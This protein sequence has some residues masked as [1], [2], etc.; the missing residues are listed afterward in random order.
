MFPLLRMLWAAQNISSAEEGA[1]F[2]SVKVNH[3]SYN[4]HSKIGTARRSW[5]IVSA[6]PTQKIMNTGQPLLPQLCPG[7]DLTL[8]KR[9]RSVNRRFT[10]RHGLA[11]TV[12][13]IEATIYCGDKI[14]FGV[15]GGVGAGPELGYK[16][17][18]KWT[19][20]PFWI[21]PPLRPYLHPICSKFQKNWTIVDAERLAMIGALVQQ[22][23]QNLLKLQ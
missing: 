17:V 1:I 20:S 18:E 8:H 7:G 6:R 23:N 4:A 15:F 13:G 5:T 12:S 3:R 11:G 9:W 19:R 16:Y 10:S 22:Q 2:R 21:N 14:W